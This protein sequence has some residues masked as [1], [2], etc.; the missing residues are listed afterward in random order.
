MK[1]RRER[2]S[3][4]DAF[5]RAGSPTVSVVASLI[6]AR[7][8]IPAHARLVEG[9]RGS[10]MMLI[11]VS[12]LLD[13]AFYTRVD[14]GEKPR[15]GEPAGSTGAIGGLLPAFSWFPA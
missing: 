1:L 8:G 12:A 2:V 11:S 15:T 10:E 5:T 3:V 7:G 13:P 14:R 4:G 6:P 9:P